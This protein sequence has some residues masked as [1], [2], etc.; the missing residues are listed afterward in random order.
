MSSYLKL[1][2]LVSIFHYI[3][4]IRRFSF[5]ELFIVDILSYHMDS[6][7]IKTDSLSHKLLKTKLCGLKL[8]KNYLYALEII[9][10]HL[11][12]KYT[13]HTR[14]YR[15]GHKGRAVA[16]AHLHTRLD[17]FRHALIARVTFC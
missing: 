8:P 10:Q 7:L 6:S 9:I 13:C 16:R 2:L 3:D 1:S 5:L 12:Y 15:C 11:T 17:L 4:K 14:I